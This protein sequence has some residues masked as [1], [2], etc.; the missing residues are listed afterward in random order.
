M[1]MGLAGVP[2]HEMSMDLAA[3]GAMNH[4]LRT[5]SQGICDRDLLDDCQQ[6]F[7]VHSHVWINILREPFRC[8]TK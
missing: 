4:P 6:I 5:A 1:L 3:I 8:L 7:P 2:R